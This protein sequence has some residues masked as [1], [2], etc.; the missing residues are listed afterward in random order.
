MASSLEHFQALLEVRSEIH[1]ST[2]IIPHSKFS[3]PTQNPELK[4]QN[5]LS[6]SLLNLNLNLNLSSCLQPP[7]SN[8]LPPLPLTPHP[9]PLPPPTSY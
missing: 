3:L 5:L 1:N 6:P 4:T 9:S 8:A 7:T 2:F